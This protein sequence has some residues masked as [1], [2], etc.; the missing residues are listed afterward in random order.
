M[1]SREDRHMI[2]QL[3]RAGAFI[4]DVAHVI[5][6]AQRMVWLYLVPAYPLQRERSSRST[7]LNLTL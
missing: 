1:L 5:E 6:C 4:V 7:W 2:K 3:H